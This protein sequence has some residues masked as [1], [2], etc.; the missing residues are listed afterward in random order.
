MTINAALQDLTPLPRSGVFGLAP[1]FSGLVGAIVGSVVGT[2]A[3]L[4]GV[5]TQYNSKGL[6]L[7][8]T[9]GASINAGITALGLLG[10]LGGL[11]PGNSAITN[12]GTYMALIVIVTQMAYFM[13][14]NRA[15][16]DC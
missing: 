12:L 16:G 13:K 2:T 4:A 5:E 8:D 3:G 11:L 10:Q 1:I 7:T 9:Q 14:L 15:I 6:C